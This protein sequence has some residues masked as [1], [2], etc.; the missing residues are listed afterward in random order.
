[1]RMIEAL[2]ADFRAL[3]TSRR[4]LR[5]F[6]SVVGSVLILIA[7]A[8]AWRGGWTIGMGARWLAAA[9]AALAG[10]G[11]LAPPAL[12]PLYRAWMG[13]ALVLGH[14]MTRVLLTLVFFLL[15]TPIG[16]IRRAVR[17]DPIDKS[18][19]SDMDT[20]WIR[21]EGTASSERLERYW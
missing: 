3:D 9:G 14:V 5:R 7:I 1:M 19:D 10:L 6:G 17:R 20:Y 2:R 21:R 13:L 18:P 11:L 16:L 4:Q 8:V 15:V 12:L